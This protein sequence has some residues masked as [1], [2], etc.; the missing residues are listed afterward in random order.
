MV[1]PRA[2]LPHPKRNNGLERLT[3]LGGH[4]APQRLFGTLANRIQEG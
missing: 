3:G 4:I 1:A 2:G